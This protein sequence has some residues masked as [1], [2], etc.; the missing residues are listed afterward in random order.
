MEVLTKMIEATSTARLISGFSVGR[1]NASM[2]I[3]H[4]LFRDD[5]IIFCGSD[6]DQWLTSA[7]FLLGLR[8]CE[9]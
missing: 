3:S 9:V 5:T 7:E 6:C 4:L 8:L 2:G 1:M